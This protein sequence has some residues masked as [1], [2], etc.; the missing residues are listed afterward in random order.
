MKDKTDRSA[1]SGIPGVERNKVI[2]EPRE[3]SP[4]RISRVIKPRTVLAA[5]PDFALALVFLSA[6]IAPERYNDDTTYYLK[7]LIAVEFGV[8]ISAAMLGLVLT[9][10][11]RTRTI[12]L[13][14]LALSL[15]FSMLVFGISDSFGVTWPVWMYWLLMLNRLMSVF[16]SPRE[17]RIQLNRNR[18]AASYFIYLSAAFLIMLPYIVIIVLTDRETFSFALPFGFLYFLLTALSELSD[19]RWADKLSRDFFRTRDLYGTEDSLD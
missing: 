17:D 3:T 7:V 11:M 16:L 9:S 15:F 8:V 12:V 18:W 14:A 10:R 5:L 4:P 19:H 6:L 13:S 2:E 1:V